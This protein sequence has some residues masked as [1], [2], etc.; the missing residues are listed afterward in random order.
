VRAAL[1]QRRAVTVL[2]RIANRV[3]GEVRYAKWELG[4]SLP[5]LDLPAETTAVLHLAHDWRDRSAEGTNVRGTRI[6]LRDARVRGL[7]RFVF[8]SSQSARID[9]LNGYGRIKWAIEQSLDGSDT[10]SARVGLVYGGARRGMYRLL[11]KLVSVS[12]LLPMIDPGRL[13]QPIH[14]E[15]VCR[16]LLALADSGVTGWVGLAGADAISFGDFLKMLAQEGFASSVRILPIPLPLAL[17]AAEVSAAIP[18]GP[19][20]DKERILGLAGTQPI[21]C[22]QHLAAMG[23]SV[24]P[25]RQGLRRDSIG[26]RALLLEARVLCWFILGRCV[27]GSLQRRY[28]RAIRAV[29]PDP[30]PLQLP[31]LAVWWPVLLRFFEPLNRSS[32]LGRRLRL[33]TALSEMSVDGSAVADALSRKSPFAKF[34]SMLLLAGVEIVAFPLRLLFA[35]RA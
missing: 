21:D 19:S 8:V 23:L 26:A 17:F 27:G 14:V 10:V 29:E 9:A 25:L 2:G 18:F 11:T 1:E 22:R 15:E 5:M 13:V 33:A 12:P 30:G 35:R 6:L 20:I 7:K 32:D 4:D 16:G 24:M 31:R 34:W 3:A 28:A